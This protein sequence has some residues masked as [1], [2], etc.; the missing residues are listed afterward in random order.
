MLLDTAAAR[1]A[2][3]FH[4]DGV[5]RER[6]AGAQKQGFGGHELSENGA[7]NGVA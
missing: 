4:T 2:F 3:G 5:G 6:D 7:V 1:S